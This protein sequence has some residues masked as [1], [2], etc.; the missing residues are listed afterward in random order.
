MGKQAFG[1]DV[2]VDEE[3]R[4]GL[5]RFDRFGAKVE[6]ERALDGLAGFDLVVGADGVFEWGGG[7]DGWIGYGLSHLLSPH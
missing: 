6:I 4:T 7:I 2:R 3:H 5:T 1:I